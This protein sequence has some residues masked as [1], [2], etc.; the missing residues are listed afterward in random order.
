MGES[1]LSSFL[2]QCCRGVC[3]TVVEGAL[4][5]TRRGHWFNTPALAH[6]NFY[7]LEAANLMLDLFGNDL[8]SSHLMPSNGN[9]TE[10]SEEVHCPRCNYVMKLFIRKRNYKGGI[11]DHPT[12]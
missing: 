3:G 4:Q 6:Q 11:H 10:V 9:T 8:C 5:H 1:N 7:F 12:Y 2:T